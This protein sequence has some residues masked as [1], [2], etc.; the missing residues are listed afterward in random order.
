MLSFLHR[1]ESFHADRIRTF[2]PYVH[3]VASLES[4]TALTTQHE[5]TF[6][7]SLADGSAIARLTNRARYPSILGD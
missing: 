5:G 4:A 3:F 1:D 6:R 2:C 7:L